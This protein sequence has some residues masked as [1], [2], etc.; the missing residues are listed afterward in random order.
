M[1]RP[2]VTEKFGGA[3]QSKQSLRLWLRLLSCSMIIEKR[4]RL[5]LSEDFGTTLP[6]FD[7]LA[8]LQRNPAG[9]KMGELSN[10]LLVSNGNVTVIVERL[11]EEGFVKRTQDEA[12]RRI[13]RVSLT[14]LGR[15]RFAAM[16]VR[17]EAWIE[18]MMGELKAADVD[19]LLDALEKLKTS[20]ERNPI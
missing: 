5:K 11:I 14:P 7:V 20:M 6:R 15:R 4:I 8:A 9:L 13:Q 10:W 12:D 19:A 3:P 1:T 18:H 16:A 17:H 2:R